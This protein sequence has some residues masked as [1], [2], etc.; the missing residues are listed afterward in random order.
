MTEALRPAT[1]ARHYAELPQVTDADGS[2]HWITRA[3]NFVAVVS[4]TSAGAVLQRNNADEYMMLLPQR[5]VAVIEA[6]GQKLE[7]EGE[8][9][10]IVP[11]GKS[12]LR[13]PSGG[14][15]VRL[16]S[17]QA[18]D[19][20]AAAKNADVYADGAPEVA[21]IVPW[22]DPVGE[23]RLRHY[24]LATIPSPDPS[25]LKMRVFRSTNLMI[26]IFLPW[27]KRR[28]EHKLS[29]HSH[30]SF[31][32]MSL[33]LEG[34]FVHHLR[35]PWSPDKTR[36]RQDEHEHYDSP[37]ILVIPARVVHTTQDIG[38]GTTWLVD[39]FGPPRM[40]FSLKPGFVLNAAEYPMPEQETAAA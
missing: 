25:P 5:T 8:S 6:G 15:V 7:S 28:D 3:A 38:G 30:D 24:D 10:I 23:F 13:M 37:A 40:D 1:H 9:L 26:N 2:R 20:A 21:P 19:L 29:P 12:Q 22:P 34:S 14:R 36:W 17:N 35:Y 39:V 33:C 18:S 31:E 32:Q 27:T 11:P 16:F 4:E